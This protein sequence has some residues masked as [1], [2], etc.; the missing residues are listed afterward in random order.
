MSLRCGCGHAEVAA[1]SGDWGI[2]CSNGC[3]T[4]RDRRVLTT[5]CALRS[6]NSASPL[7]DIEGDKI[8]GCATLRDQLYSSS[9]S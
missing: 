5:G 2:P 1:G 8:Y 7:G 9:L 3:A 6:A 4:L